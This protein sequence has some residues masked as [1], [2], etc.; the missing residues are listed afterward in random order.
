MNTTIMHGSRVLRTMTTDLAEAYRGGS[1]VER[2]CYQLAAVLVLSGLVHLGV[3]MVTGGP[4][5][6]PLS[7]RKPATF[8][9][10]FGLTLATLTW[11]L[12]FVPM[13]GVTRSRLLAVFGAAC[14]VEVAGITVQAWR[15]VP[16]HF[17]PPAD[18]T[19]VDAVAAVAAAS[20]A[21]AIVGVITA[22]TVKTLR[23]HEEVPPSMR[24]AL[25]VGF[26]SLMVALAIGVLMMARGAVL[27]RVQGDVAQAFAF[28]AALKP[29]HAATMHGVLVLPALAWL[30]RYAERPERFRT[31]AVRLATAGYGAFATTIVLDPLLNSALPSALAVAGTLTLTAAAALTVHAIATPPTHPG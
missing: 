23:H 7:W 29:G 30:L 14:A 31:N 19:A 5:T 20:G 10:S 25:R 8:G 4:W 6:G 11:V 22:A 9:L 27:T 18:A 15:R 16:S 17:T 2:G 13:R 3:L 24:L 21:V 28:S 26:L 12:S 1:T